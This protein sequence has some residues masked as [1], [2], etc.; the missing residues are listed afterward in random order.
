MK[1]LLIVVFLSCS[2]GCGVDIEVEPNGIKYSEIKKLCDPEIIYIGDDIS[3][4]YDIYDDA[5]HQTKVTN[6]DNSG[7]VI[8]WNGKSS[9]SDIAKNKMRLYIAH[10]EVCYVR[11]D[12]QEK[13]THIT[14]KYVSEEEFESIAKG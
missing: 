10:G 4:A 8:F 5:R 1:Y 2:I 13:I 12:S 3:S 11:H 6:S 9:L 14:Y 7:Q